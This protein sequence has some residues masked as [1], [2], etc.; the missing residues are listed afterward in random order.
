MKIYSESLNIL[1]PSKCEVIRYMRAGKD[2]AGELDR[3]IDTSIDK[4]YKSITPRVCYVYL[5]L[6]IE[7]ENVILGKILFKSSSL[8]KRLEG[9]HRACVFAATVGTD[10]DR[11]I[12]ASGAISSVLGL[13]A[14]AAGTAAVEELCDELCRRLEE[15]SNDAGE[16]TISRFSAGYGDLSIEYQKDIVNLLETKKHI[17]VSLSMGGMMTPTKTV[18]AIVGIKN[19]IW[20]S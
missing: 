8:A 2:I 13:A 9:C 3:I 4:V 14:D 12:R 15:K 17:G 10:V 7:S 16:C 20:Q 19:K 5:P 1:A 11:V 18:T 6:E